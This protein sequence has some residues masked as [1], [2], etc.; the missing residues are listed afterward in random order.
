MKRSLIGI[1][2]LRNR[3]IVC[4]IA[5]IS[6]MSGHVLAQSNVTV[7]GVVDAAVEYSR[8]GDGGM[9]RL[10]SGGYQGNRLGFRGSE[11][12]GG[13]VRAVFNLENGFA[14]DNGTFTQGG[15]LFGRQAFVGLEG[16]WGVITAGRHQS[17]YYY[18]MLNQ[19]AFQW[20]M[21]GG[22]LALTRTSGAARATSPLLSVYGTLGRIDNSVLYTSPVVGGLSARLIYGFGEV[23]G[24][25]AAGR[26]AGASLRYQNGPLDLNVVY[27]ENNDAFDRGGQKAMNIGGSYALGK[28]KVY[29]GYLRETSRTATSAVAALPQETRL[30]LYN[31]GLRFQT[32][33]NLTLIGQV[34]RLRDRSEGLTIDRDGTSIAFGGEYALSKRTLVYAS[35]GSIENQNGSSYS[36]G[37]GT[38]A[39]G[40]VT[41]DPRA[42]AASIG[43]RHTF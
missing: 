1:P 19:D 43:V 3:L 11:D 41:G 26:A 2:C 36:L 40:P 18:S 8:Q 25:S 33:A 12:L 22:L 10:Q 34:I 21:N 31:I 4:G 23:A 38:A 29:A 14:V 37:T 20:A 39:G 13:G 5:A 16:A 35:V 27:I 6:L 15:R 32:T 42:R 24:D 30:D 9:T 28:A 17:P 7:Y